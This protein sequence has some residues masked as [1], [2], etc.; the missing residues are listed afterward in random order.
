MDLDRVLR[1]VDNGL[2]T[3]NASP[4]E[5]AKRLLQKHLEL[6]GIIA[7]ALL[8]WGGGDTQGQESDARAEADNLIRT[9]EKTGLSHEELSSLHAKLDLL[10]GYV[11]SEDDNFAFPDGETIKTGHSLCDQDKMDREELIARALAYS[12]PSAKVTAN[13]REWQPYVPQA[14]AFLHWRFSE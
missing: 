6:Q 2:R 8:R 7:V 5:E 3:G 11:Q 10:A 14:K 13:P 1:L 4:I 9:L 12:D